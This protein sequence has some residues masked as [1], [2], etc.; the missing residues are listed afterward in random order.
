M[1][2]DHLSDEILLSLLKN[3]SLLDVPP[4]D[5]EFLGRKERLEYVN[6][7]LEQM[8]TNGEKVCLIQKGYEGALPKYALYYEAKD[9]DEEL[10]PFIEGI[11]QIYLTS[12]AKTKWVSVYNLVIQ[13]LSANSEK[14]LLESMRAQI[15][16]LQDDRVQE[17]VVDGETCKHFISRQFFDHHEGI[18]SNCISESCLNRPK[19]AYQTP[20][21]CSQIRKI[22]D[23][24]QKKVNE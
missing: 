1:N 6:F 22:R 17:K 24:F 13:Q 14:T 16:S 15:H 21:Y 23:K 12:N 9:I 18:H 19:A 20:E 2:P 5:P 7:W 8:E 3:D 10:R 11:S 4:E